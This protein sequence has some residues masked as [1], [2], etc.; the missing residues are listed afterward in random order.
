MFGF[1]SNL[2]S[3]SALFDDETLLSIG[4][5]FEN[6]I[7]LQSENSVYA[8]D[9][10]LKFVRYGY[11]EYSHKEFFDNITRYLSSGLS[12]NPEVE[13]YKPDTYICGEPFNYFASSDSTYREAFDTNVAKFIY[14]YFT[15]LAIMLNGISYNGK[16][17]S[18]KEKNFIAG[19]CFEYIQSTEY[20]DNY[21]LIPNRIRDIK[22]DYWKLYDLKNE[23]EKMKY[24]NDYSLFFRQIEGSNEFLPDL[25]K[26]SSNQ[27]HFLFTLLD[28]NF[29]IYYHTLINYLAELVW[30]AKLLRNFKD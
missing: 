10:T 18:K 19:L 28:K 21:Y 2:F 20:A 3:E 25:K 17:F 24:I 9:A 6:K 4:S 16:H 27:K 30:S 8:L 7:V 5:K 26:L 1:L 15:R 29:Q 22:K 13:R 12:D 23:N 14:Y 11:N